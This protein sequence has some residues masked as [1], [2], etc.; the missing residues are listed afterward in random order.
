MDI[1]EQFFK[2]QKKVGK[3]DSL[4]RN[5]RYD[6][7]EFFRVT[8]IRE[9]RDVFQVVIEDIERYLEELRERECT[10]NTIN[11]RISAIKSFVRYL[12]KNR[13]RT[14][15]RLKRD[16]NTNP[17]VLEYMRSQIEEYEEII[18]LERVKAMEKERLPFTIDE[19]WLLFNSTKNRFRGLA[20]RNYLMIKFAA[21]GTGARNT[22]VRLLRKSDLDCS[23]CNAECNNCIPTAKLERKGKVGTKIRVRI[24][25]GLCQELYIYI[26]D[27]DHPQNV[28]FPSRSGGFLSISSLDKILYR[29]MENAG[30]ERKGRTFHSLRHTFITEGI[31]NGTPYGHMARQVDHAG[32]LGITGKYE[33]MDARDLEI[34]FIQL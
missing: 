34:H 11:R 10:G 12:L 31:K 18:A 20:Y 14:L 23:S 27:P 6:L 1:L 24:E 15:R 17:E 33:H 28:V 9:S 19:L 8:G 2:K 21:V 16:K 3:S 7:E 30:I 22:A 4:V 32:K 13:R 26:H 25:K 5:Y 29:I